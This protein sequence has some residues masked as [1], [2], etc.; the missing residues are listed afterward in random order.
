M[1]P[2]NGKPD[3]R[4]P[5]HCKFHCPDHQRKR[6]P[7]R[8]WQSARHHSPRPKPLPPPPPPPKPEEDPP[9]KRDTQQRIK[10]SLAAH[11]P[12]H[13]EKSQPRVFWRRESV[14]EEDEHGEMV[15]RHPLGHEYVLSIPLCYD[16][17]VREPD[18]PLVRF[19][20]LVLAT[21]IVW[22]FI[23]CLL[24]LFQYSESMRTAPADEVTPVGYTREATLVAFLAVF[25]LAFVL[26]GLGKGP[27]DEP[28]KE[29]DK[30]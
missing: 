12:R 27:G 15:V 7:W 28:Q 22:C 4:P 29:C 19:L 2:G 20:K 13:S 21:V 26:S 14:G 24:F 17:Q 25:L 10:P 23:F 9:P 18:S 16:P 1:K 30:K 6:T 5:S 3:K 11:P 8:P